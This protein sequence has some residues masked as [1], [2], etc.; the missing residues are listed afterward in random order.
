MIDYLQGKEKARAKA[1]EYFI[2][3]TTT[4][5]SWAELAEQQKEL[6]KLARRYGLIKEFKENGII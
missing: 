5:T 2:K 4:R 6:A 1:Q 3:N